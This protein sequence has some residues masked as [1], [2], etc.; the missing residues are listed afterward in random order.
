MINE[1][2]KYF[3]Y[4]ETYATLSSSNTIMFFTLEKNLYFYYQETYAKSIKLLMN[5]FIFY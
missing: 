5:N 3:Y 4:Q 2:K 1:I